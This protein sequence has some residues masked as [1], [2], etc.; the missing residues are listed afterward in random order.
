VVP[1][2]RGGGALPGLAALPRQQRVRS[3]QVRDW[4]IMTSVSDPYSF[5][6]I[7]IQGFEDQKFIKIYR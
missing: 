6:P 2:L 5:D 4:N 1:G 7:R 3:D